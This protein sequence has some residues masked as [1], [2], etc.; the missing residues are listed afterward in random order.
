MAV[1]ADTMISPQIAFD[2]GPA[3]KS[4]DNTSV[5]LFCF[6]YLELS[7]EISLS[8]TKETVISP[9]LT[10]SFFKALRIDFF[11]LSG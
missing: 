1:S 6:R 4:N 10:P 7:L 5:G 8:L 9:L 3:A 2:F 11:I